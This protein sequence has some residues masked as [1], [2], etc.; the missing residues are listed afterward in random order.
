MRELSLKQEDRAIVIG[1]DGS[2]ELRAFL[3]AN[4]ISIG[5]VFSVNYSPS[6]THLINLTIGSKMM[7]LRMDDF[8]KIEW[9]K[10]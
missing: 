5:T 4:G 7:S 8:T 1:I 6:F 2:L 10:I 3:L 9:I